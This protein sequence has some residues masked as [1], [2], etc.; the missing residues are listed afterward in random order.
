M[1]YIDT[2]NKL[3]KKAGVAD[4]LAVAVPGLATAGSLWWLSKYIPGVKKSK[5]LRGALAAAGGAGASGLMYKY[6]GDKNKAIQDSEDKAT[7]AIESKED[8]IRGLRRTAKGMGAENTDRMSPVGLMSEIAM[9]ADNSRYYGNTLSDE[10]LGYID[11]MLYG[12]PQILN[13][14][15]QQNAFVNGQRPSYSQATNRLSDD[16]RSFVSN[17]LSNEPKIQSRVLDAL[18]YYDNRPVFTPADINTIQSLLYY[19]PDILDKLRM[20]QVIP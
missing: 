13:K 19:D 8:I 5:W 20:L 15:K 9:R 1:N 11:D 12:R 2:Y 4:T 18:N 17:M 7:K 14:V 3:Y 16:D 6:V 10:E